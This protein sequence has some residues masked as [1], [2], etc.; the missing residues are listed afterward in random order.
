MSW[1]TVMPLLLE[2]LPTN[3]ETTAAAKLN[4]HHQRYDDVTPLMSD[5]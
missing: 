1:N 3:T 5:W 4:H 2:Y